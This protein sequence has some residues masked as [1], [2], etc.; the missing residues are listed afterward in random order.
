MRDIRVD[1]IAVAV[2]NLEEALKFYTEKLKLPCITIETVDKQGVRVA[3]IDL[4]N[5]HIE[6]LEP[7][8]PETPVG[9]F[10]ARRGQGLHHICLGVPDIDEELSCLREGGV[11]LIDQTA[12]IGA[13]GARIAF[14]HPKSTGGVLMEL[15]QRQDE[16]R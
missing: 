3:K 9:R 8:A 2:D 15:S 12:R 5:T 14:V 16:H 10:L 6:L 13:E 1:H 11:N 7:L 4:G